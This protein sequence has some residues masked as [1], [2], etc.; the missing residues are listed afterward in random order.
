MDN[1]KKLKMAIKLFVIDTKC[2]IPDNSLVSAMTPNIMTVLTTDDKYY[3]ISEVLIL[4]GKTYA[5]PIYYKLHRKCDKKRISSYDKLSRE[6][7]IYEF[8][9]RYNTDFKIKNVK[10]KSI[11]T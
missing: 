1:K 6:M 2:I 11:I 9:E 7:A 8:N 3:L 5:C 4:D 10:I